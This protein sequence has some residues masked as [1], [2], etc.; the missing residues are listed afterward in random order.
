MSEETISEETRRRYKLDDGHSYYWTFRQ[1]NMAAKGRQILFLTDSG[2]WV[3][4]EALEFNPRMT[5]HEVVE[6]VEWL[7]AS[8]MHP[9]QMAAAIGR[10]AS[11]IEKLARNIDRKDIAALFYAEAF[12]NDAP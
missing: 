10:S 3:E 8:G 11:A 1:A 7:A 5:P 4:V 9:A 2:D 12:R 6:E